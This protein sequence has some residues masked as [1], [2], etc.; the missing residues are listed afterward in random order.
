MSDNIH[1]IESLNDKDLKSQQYWI[2]KWTVDY[3]DGV[4]QANHL[5]RQYAMNAEAV[6]NCYCGNRKRVGY[7]S[8]RVID[9]YRTT[10][11][12]L[13]REQAYGLEKL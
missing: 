10:G 5:I 12:I 4:M 1:L 13:T 3:L 8:Q 6:A 11:D 7:E 9:Y 2:R